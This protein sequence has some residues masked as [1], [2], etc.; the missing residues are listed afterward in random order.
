[1]GLKVLGLALLVLG[2]SVNQSPDHAGIGN[3]LPFSLLLEEVEAT[4]GEFKCNLGCGLARH[5]L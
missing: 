2:I 5:E 4:A 1:M 3:A